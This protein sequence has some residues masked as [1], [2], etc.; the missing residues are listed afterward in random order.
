MK[1]GLLISERLLHLTEE[2][3]HHSDVIC[4]VFHLDN[5]NVASS[6]WLLLYIPKIKPVNLLL[7]A[8]LIQRF[9][10]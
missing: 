10:T 8:D 4:V 6:A 2:K 5:R 3:R 7:I 1:H 9:T